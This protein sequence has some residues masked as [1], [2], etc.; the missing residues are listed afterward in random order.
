MAIEEHGAGKQLV[1]FRVTPWIPTV[2]LIPIASLVLLASAAALDHAWFAA[3]VLAVSAATLS[4]HVALG[5]G[6][7]LR[8]LIAS[9]LGET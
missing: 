6:R 5:S 9:S 3:A 8:S 1:R 4:A 2:V 7:A